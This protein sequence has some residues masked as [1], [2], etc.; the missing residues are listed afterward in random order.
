MNNAQRAVAIVSDGNKRARDHGLT[1]PD[2]PE[3]RSYRIGYDDG[4]W[5]FPKTPDPDRSRWDNPAWDRARYLEGYEAGAKVRADARAAYGRPER[6]RPRPETPEHFRCHRPADARYRNGSEDHD[7]TCA[8]IL[9]ERPPSKSHGIFHRC[10]EVC[11]GCGAIQPRDEFRNG[12]VKWRG[13]RWPCAGAGRKEA[14]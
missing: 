6:V 11:I 5:D 2:G 8:S 7:D 4:L 10:W 12:T 3:R 14:A 1:L 13:W 9:T